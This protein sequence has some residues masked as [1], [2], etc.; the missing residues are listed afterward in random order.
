MASLM[1]PSSRARWV[2]MCAVWLV[3]GGAQ[4]AQGVSVRTQPRD[5]QSKVDNPWPKTPGLW[6]E[7][8]GTRPTDRGG[9]TVQ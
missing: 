8:K 7:N 6:G 9:P 5:G 1:H 2:S 4:G 3:A